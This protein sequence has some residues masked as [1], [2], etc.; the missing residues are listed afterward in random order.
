MNRFEE[1]NEAVLDRTTGLMWPK[2]AALSV[3]PLSWNEAFEFI[4]ELNRSAL[5]G[6]SDWKLPNRRELFSLVSHDSI[7]PCLPSGHPF[8][9]VFNGYYWTSTP[10]AR[11]PDQ[12]WYIHLGGARVYKG[13]KQ[14]SYMVWPVRPAEDR[15][16]RTGRSGQQQRFI[17]KD[18]WVK[19]N[20]TG[21]IWL[22]NADIVDRATDWQTVFDFVDRMNSEGLYG[23]NDWRVPGIVELESITDM[24][25]HSPALPAGYPFTSVQHYYWSSTTSMYDR[26]YAWVLYM[27]D[28]AV[29]VG[30][31]PLTEFY[32]W[33][34]R[35]EFAF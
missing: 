26:N 2:D 16:S 24:D 9:N 22:K 29:G 6:Y 18:H 14:G 5:Y 4:R 11:L 21:L 8:V 30:Y 31:K 3:F 7:N 17:E 15:R 25:R 32:L 28:G 35:G 20:E 1:L 12:A 13:M 33:P 27:I 10:C 34:V 23:C 19:D